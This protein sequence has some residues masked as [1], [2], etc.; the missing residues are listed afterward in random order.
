MTKDNNFIRGIQQKNEKVKEKD[1]P[2]TINCSFPTAVDAFA[3]D[4]DFIRNR[5]VSTPPPL[6]PL[7]WI[8]QS[9]PISVFQLQMKDIYW[10]IDDFL[11][12]F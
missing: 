8:R 10:Y 12:F 6:P 1:G 4:F 9:E 5:L 11:G 7:A 2:I 3:T